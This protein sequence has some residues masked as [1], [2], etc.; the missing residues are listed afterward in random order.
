MN[1]SGQLTENP[2]EHN[3]I[4]DLQKHGSLSW[5]FQL[6]KIPNIGGKVET[7]TINTPFSGDLVLRI[8]GNCYGVKGKPSQC[9]N[10]NVRLGRKG[11]I[12]PCQLYS[13]INI[14]AKPSKIHT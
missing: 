9:F 11:I 5:D 3:S 10:I 4:E 7:T 12:V 6:R 1:S 2:M 8:I 13:T 14:L